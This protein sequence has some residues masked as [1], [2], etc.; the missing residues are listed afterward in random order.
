MASPAYSALTRK[1]DT[2]A[3]L[4]RQGQIRDA[5]PSIA[6]LCY[7]LVKETETRDTMRQRVLQMGSL[8][9]LALDADLASE[10]VTPLL[11]SMC[12]KL[13]CWQTLMTRC[14]EPSS[15]LTV[16]LAMCLVPLR[17]NTTDSVRQL[18]RFMS[19]YR[20]M[21]G[22][23]L[24]F[25]KRA[26]DDSMIHTNG[27]TPPLR[28]EADMLAKWRW[29]CSADSPVRKPG[30]LQLADVADMPSDYSKALID[31]VFRDQDENFIHNWLLRVKKPTGDVANH[32]AFHAP[33]AIGAVAAR[34]V[35]QP[36]RDLIRI[37]SEETGLDPDM[38]ALTLAYAHRDRSSSVQ[39]AGEVEAADGPRTPYGN[40][41]RAAAVDATIERH[42]RADA[43]A[44]AHHSSRSAR[45]RDDDSSS[46]SRPR[47]QQSMW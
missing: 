19:H 44:T 37:A 29:L 41:V 3:A 46:S 47:K 10:F 43:L 4:K 13:S 40:L 39:N 1:I 38:L 16:A 32:I 9:E 45:P 18:S 34:T 21:W 28:D 14:L 11:L 22:D 23:L 12:G 20:F 42:Q 30:M 35:Q 15:P 26:M 31:A 25:V 6:S 33:D 36:Q 5:P 27:W 2:L 7:D 17:A 24:W 8:V